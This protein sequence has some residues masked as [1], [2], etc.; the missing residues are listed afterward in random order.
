[1]VNKE[2]Y[3]EFGKVLYAMAMADGEIQPNEKSV[4]FTMVRE[5]LAPLEKQSDE[6]GTDLAF[7]VLFSFEMEEEVNDSVENAINSFLFF[8]SNHQIKISPKVRNACLNILRK[9]AKS[10]GR[11][12]KPEG[13]LLRRIE[14][15]FEELT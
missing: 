11:I 2:F 5:E 1:M 15:R 10:Y 13:A 4:M 14:D 3:K 8:L 7:Y 9:I 12:T 6:Y